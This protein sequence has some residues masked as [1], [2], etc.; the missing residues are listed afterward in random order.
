M[1]VTYPYNYLHCTLSSGIGNLKQPAWFLTL[2]D[3]THHESSGV[4]S[5]GTATNQYSLSDM[6]HSRSAETYSNVQVHE[7][8]WSQLITRDAYTVYGT[9]SSQRKFQLVAVGKNR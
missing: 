8:Q 5:P 7:R 4:T 6:V 9:T 2:S 1:K 3:T